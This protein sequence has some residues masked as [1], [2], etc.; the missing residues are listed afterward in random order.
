MRISTRG[1]YA[2][3]ALLFLA[4]L[5]EGEFASLRIVS[6][7]TGVSEGYLEQLLIPLKK[8][9][10]VEGVRGARGGYFISRPLSA[11][12]L[13]EIFRAVEGPMAPVPCLSTE[14]CEAEQQCIAR[15]TWSQLF[16]LTNEALESLSIQDLVLAYRSM[17]MAGEV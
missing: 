9:D 1:Q 2:L 11:I 12:N 4:L 15:K 8:I 3:E 14:N 16:K 7:N 13:G 17:S 6:E 10:I 5:T